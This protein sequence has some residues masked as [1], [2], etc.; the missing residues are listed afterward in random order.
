MVL[1]RRLRNLPMLLLLGLLFILMSSSGHVML[2]APYLFWH[3]AFMVRIIALLFVGMFLEEWAFVAILLDTDVNNPINSPAS[4]PRKTTI[5]LITGIRRFLG[6][7]AP[8]STTDPRQ[9]IDE[10][11]AD[12]KDRIF[13]EA[14]RIHTAGCYVLVFIFM[15]AAALR[16]QLNNDVALFAKDS[17]LIFGSFYYSLFPFFMV[18]FV[19][20][21][22]RWILHHV[23]WW[24]KQFRRIYDW[25]GR[26]PGLRRTMIPDW[27]LSEVTNE[28]HLFHEYH[29][30]AMVKNLLTAAVLSFACIF[31]WT[32]HFLHDYSTVAMLVCFLL[33]GLVG[34]YGWI[35]FQRRRMRYEFVVA[36]SIGVAIFAM[37]R[38]DSL[39]APVNVKSD[40]SPTSIRQ[41]LIDVR[42][43]ALQ[44]WNARRQAGSEPSKASGVAPAPSPKTDMMPAGHEAQLLEKW[45]KSAQNSGIDE[46]GKQ[47]KSSG[48]PVLVLIANTGGGIRAQVWSSAVLSAIE[49]SFAKS[50]SAEEDPTAENDDSSKEDIPARPAIN[51]SR[52]VRLISGASGGMVGAGYWTATLLPDASNLPESN[53]D[54]VFHQTGNGQALSSEN[55]LTKMSTD[56][57][58]R[59]AR[60]GFYND[61]AWVPFRLIG[62]PRQP[63]RGEA[64]EAAMTE[65]D[66]VMA[67]PF[68]AL[69]SHEDAGQLPTLIYTPTVADDG[70]RFLICNQ[71]LEYVFYSRLGNRS[72]PP[73][74]LEPVP[75]SRETQL[76]DPSQ[77]ERAYEQYVSTADDNESVGIYSW[78]VNYNSQED[79]QAKSRMS[80]ATAARLSA[81]FPI[82]LDSPKLPFKKLPFKN[83]NESLRIMDAGYLDNHGLFPLASWL[84]ENRHWIKR[85]TGGVLLI[86]ISAAQ[87]PKNRAKKS[88]HLSIPEA[89]GFITT[90][91]NK[92]LF[93]ADRLVAQSADFFNTAEDPQFFQLVTFAYDGDASLSWYLSN[94]E[95]LTLIYP[96]LSND[97]AEKI[98]QHA[99]TELGRPIEFPEQA[100]DPA[101][102]TRLLSFDNDVTESPLCVGAGNI[103]ATKLQK[104]ER[105]RRLMHKKIRQVDIW[106]RRR[107]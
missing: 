84:F 37:N 36:I 96:F 4:S 19:F 58:G 2:G 62:L 94:V 45:I 21:I 29:V 5:S 52:H 104:A 77:S 106:W 47:L 46:N 38:F 90:S 71:P 75:P 66:P 48:K 73:P 42:N 49:G 57:L 12:D 60:Q 69:K 39:V 98:R 20:L 55:L 64:L 101:M 70:R 80:L 89:S 8:L 105:L 92:T 50:K 27:V 1:V 68:S 13:Q 86:E 95:K 85:H 44:Q 103:Q 9:A 81:N 23:Q 40:T 43:E 24:T 14:C 83:E 74:D 79:D 16:Y 61:L 63:S 11:S 56:L 25:L 3:D 93:H 82:F 53:G 30:I 28:S 99:S 32:G 87:L 65:I 6:I 26:I 31:Y 35:V 102:N 41:A 22:R 18:H 17:T 7:D 88:G 10:L 97:Q 54:L 15:M 51:F 107:L 100:T 67:E 72:A 91:F 78:R 59:V 33:S 76:S 34:I